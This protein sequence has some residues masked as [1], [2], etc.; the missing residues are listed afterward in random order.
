[1]ADKYRSSIDFA[2]K[3]VLKLHSMPERSFEEKQTT[4]YLMDLLKDRDL[5]IIDTGLDTGV[6]AFLDCKKAETVALRADID[7]VSTEDGACHLCGHD[8]HTASLLG[9]LDYMETHRDELPVNVLFVFQ[10]AEEYTMGVDAMME[11][12]F[13]DRLPQRPVRMFGIHNR[14]EIMLGD[15][16]VHE[17]ALMA[18]KSDFIVTYEGLTGHGGTPHLCIDPIVA[19]A[20][21]IMG[22]NTI[23]S[24]NVDPMRPAVCSICSIHSGTDENFAPDTAVMTGSL[25]SLDE[26]TH[27]RLRERLQKL[28]EETAEE[29]ECTCKFEFNLEVPAIINT[30]EMTETARKAAAAAVGEDHI[31][32]SVPNLG[33]ED[34]AV[35]RKEIPSFFYWVGAG[36]SGEV[37]HAWH[38]PEFR[39]T[40]EYLEVAVPLLVE[41]VKVQ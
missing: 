13:M 38:S 20:Q 26:K 5:T 36:V 22:A 8:Y 32:D 9:A 24:R 39:L 29:F 6:T 3:A 12:G 28:A 30:P 1:M 33:S 40:P 15:V 21:F 23:V 31:V 35:F 17:G 41:S 7:A 25:R 18:F 16:V 2:K 10:P 4:A 27:M 19:S 11:K 37:N 14:P 34:F